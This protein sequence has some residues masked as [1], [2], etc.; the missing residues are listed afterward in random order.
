MRPKEIVAALQGCMFEAGTS[1][2]EFPALRKRAGV[3]ALHKQVRSSL[4]C[5]MQKKSVA[6]RY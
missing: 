2:R 5:W 6:S 1:A 3:P 4:I